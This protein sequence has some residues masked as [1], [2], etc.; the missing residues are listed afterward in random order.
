MPEPVIGNIERA[1]LER[2][3]PTITVWNRLEGRPRTADF[4]RALRA[5]IRDPLWMLT[6]QWQMGEFRGDDAGSPAFAKI[7]VASARF[8]GYRP[9]GH[10]PRPFDENTPLEAQVEQQPLVFERGEQ[11][12]ALDIRL[13]MGRQWFKLLRSIGDFR[14]EFVA[15][16]GIDLPDPSQQEAAEV[17]AHSDVWQRV[18][19]VAGR[20]MD[21]YR[22]YRYLLDDPAHHAYDDTTIPSGRHAD[23]DVLAE[24]FVQWFQDLFLQPADPE[25]RAWRPRYLEYQFA[26]S[27][28]G[29]SVLTAEEYHHGRLD[30]YNLDVSAGE[31]GLG[32]SAPSPSGALPP[33]T[34]SFLPAPLSFEGMPH[35]RWWTFEESRTNFGDVNP[36]TTDLAKLLLIEFGLVYANDWFLFPLTLPTGTTTRVRGLAITNVFGERVWVEAAGRGQD[37]DWQRWSMYTLA[38]RGDEDLAEDTRFLLLPTV[39]KIQQGQPLEDVLLIRDEM[40]NMVWGIETRVPLPDGRSKPGLE[41]A[42]DRRRFHERLVTENP[43]PPPP[44]PAAPMRYQVMAN[45]VPENWIPFIPVHV[46]NDNR[47]I[48]LQRA[49][50]PRLIARDPAPMTKVRPLTALLREGLDRGQP[51]FVHEEEVPPAGAHVRQAYQRTRWYQ[52][53]VV[54]WLGAQ[55]QTGRGGGASGLRFDYLA[56]AA[57]ALP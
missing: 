40:A 30:W 31:D 5:E 21:G 2:R 56:P 52:G 41:A 51:Y 44:E 33:P 32:V 57:D 1:L 49:A 12:I 9:A 47:E 46:P 17:S 6:K 23:V 7:H 20:A 50:L 55:K 8:D 11:A 37:E 36:G 4:D 22:L 26:V 27:A 43:G 14:N 53:R 24:R 13:L 19:A 34:Q 10:A 48:Q 54:V 18:A 16:Y 35:S 39:P 42:I 38:M 45:H 15:N 25:Q 29:G 28:S 3:F